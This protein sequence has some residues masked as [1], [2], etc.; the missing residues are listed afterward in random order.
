MRCCAHSWKGVNGMND[1][2]HDSLTAHLSPLTLTDGQ[3]RRMLNTIT[4]GTKMK[5]KFTAAMALAL[6]LI[7][8]A[9]AALAVSLWQQAGE[10]AAPLEAEHGVYDEWRT[11]DK[12]ALIRLLVQDGALANSDDVQRLLTEECADEARAALADDIMTNFV[13]GPVDTVSLLAILETL[14]GPMEQWT[15]EEKVWYN[16]LLERNGLLSAEDT[17][18]ALPA[19]G[20][21][22]EAEA[23]AAAKALF[24]EVYGASMAAL[25]QGTVEA[26]FYCDDAD[27]PDEFFPYYKRS[28]WI[29]SIVLRNVT[30]G[31]GDPPYTS[32]HADLTHDG[33]PLAYIA[34]MNGDEGIRRLVPQSTDRPAEEAV[35]LA[36]EALGLT[37][38]DLTA[39]AYLWLY[40]LTPDEGIPYGW[41]EHIWHVTFLRNGTV[42]HEADV[43]SSD[44]VLILDK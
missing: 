31:A 41:N 5:K 3:R 2:L 30:P 18:Y 28:D 27:F 4:G 12:V 1:P 36:R 23:I 10:D 43:L 17:T 11:D 20:D 38:D 8:T 33:R 21:A 13:S 14:H 42:C 9:A 24:H 25:D 37:D 16:Q 22:T 44:T 34:G 7:L 6:A 32:F 15:M 29:W 40:T 35:H 26:T 19:V 39:E